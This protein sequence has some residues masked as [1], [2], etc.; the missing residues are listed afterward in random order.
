MSLFYPDNDKR[1]KRVL[2]LASDTQKYFSWAETDYNRFAV[3]LEDVNSQIARIYREAGWQDPPVVR[4]EIFKL[5]DEE[6]EIPVGEVDL[7]TMENED[8]FLPATK[9]LDVTKMITDV[10]GF[11]EA[12]RYLNLG[13]TKS[14]VRAGMIPPETARE[15]LI[16]MHGQSFG[17]ELTFTGEGDNGMGAADIVAGM[18]LVG[19][20]FGGVVLGVDALDGARARN[21][22]RNAI[23]EVFQM[24]AEAKFYREKAVALLPSLETIQSYLSV[25]AGFGLPNPD[26]VITEIVTKQISLS[27]AKE[28]AVTPNTVNADLLKMDQER[29][30]WSNEDPH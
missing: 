2:E 30:S 14:M 13:A 11:A 4:V 9:T 26:G 5:P 23:D 28:R 19:F 21:K 7:P 24:R 29:N 10:P 17:Q 12:M 20:A 8:Y 6:V 16:R 3:L 27:V 25:I 18:V 22:L 15:V 1:E